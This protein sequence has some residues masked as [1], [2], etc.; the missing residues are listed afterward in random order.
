MGAGG[1]R[2]Q[3][4]LDPDTYIPFRLSEKTVLSHDTRR[5]R[6]SLQTPFHTLGLPIGQHVSMKFIDTDGKTVTRSYTPT[7][8]DVDVRYEEIMRGGGGRGV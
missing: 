3:K 4:A 6:F 5:F 1:E 2:W 7:S 8:S